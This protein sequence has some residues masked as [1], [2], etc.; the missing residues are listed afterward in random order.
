MS[1]LS[2]GKARATRA[3][4][5]DLLVA[6][7]VDVRRRNHDDLGHWAPANEG[8]RGKG[9]RTLIRKSLGPGA[10][11]EDVVRLA[12]ESWTLY[13]AL[14]RELPFTGAQV[15]SLTAARA[16]W[17]VLSSYYT[18]RAAEVG[19]G[20]VEGKELL[21]LAL[22]LDV[23][24]ERLAISAADISVR[25]ARAKPPEPKGHVPIWLARPKQGTSDE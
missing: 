7:P 21:D 2:H 12:R 11:T 5:S 8:G 3:R 15:S 4:S 22:K 6:G 19:L 14:S 25:M 1:E 23:R 24:A 20:S 9:W 13:L 17:T 18:A 16:R 10:T